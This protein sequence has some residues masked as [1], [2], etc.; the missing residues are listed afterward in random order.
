M[1]Q[2]VK[3]KGEY[4]GCIQVKE[5]FF[6]IVRYDKLLLLPHMYGVGIEHG[7]VV[8]DKAV[9]FKEVEPDNKQYLNAQDRQHYI[10]YIFSKEAFLLIH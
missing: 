5:G 10:L 2:P 6:L 9:T 3:G 1:S 4:T 7:G 8:V